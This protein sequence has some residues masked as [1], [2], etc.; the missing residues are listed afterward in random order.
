MALKLTVHMKQEG[1]ILPSP[2]LNTACHC[3]YQSQSNDRY[4]GP[5]PT[6]LVQNKDSSHR[7]KG[8]ARHTI[9]MVWLY[10]S[11]PPV[12]MREILFIIQMIFTCLCG[13]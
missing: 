1:G 5:R 8:A 3:A 10:R 4:R 7:H 2:I 12:G 13:A 6:E 9:D 11:A